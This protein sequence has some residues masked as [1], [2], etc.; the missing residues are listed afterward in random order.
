MP[1]LSQRP[2]DIEPNLDYELGR[3]STKT[4]TRISINKD[5]R[6]KFLNF[7]TS[8]DAIW[9]ANFRDLT[10]AITRMATLASR[11]RITNQ[12]V[13]EEIQGLRHRWQNKSRDS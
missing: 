2:E 6:Q 11:G 3:F 13:K 8:P 9:A 12:E 10:G 4:G 1:G 7:A 5:A